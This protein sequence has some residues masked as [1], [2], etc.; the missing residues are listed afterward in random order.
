MITLL[1]ALAA[2]AAVAQSRGCVYIENLELVPDST[3]TVPVMLACLEPTQGLQFKM[4]LP[5]GLILEEM[6]LTKRSR[7]LDM[8]LAKKH[9]GDTW[10][11]AVYTM[12]MAS[13][14]PDTTAVIHATLRALPQFQGGEIHIWKCQGCSQDFTTIN[15]DDSYTTV[16]RAA[17]P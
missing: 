6:E 10:N 15:Y 3:V 14:P 2:V 13:F 5:D 11:V 16:M 12:S 4:S 9:K 17:L 8:N 1:A 7:R